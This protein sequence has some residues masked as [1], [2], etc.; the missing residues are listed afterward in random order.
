MFNKKRF[1]IGLA[2]TAGFIFLL[3]RRTDPV[4]IIESLR[5]ANYYLVL[6][7]VAVYFIGFWFKVAR[8]AYILRPIKKIPT[9]RLFS[10]TVIGYMV[11]NLLPLRIGELVRSYLISEKENIKKSTA[12]GTIAVERIFDGL[13]LIFFILIIS[14]F[15]PVP[16]WLRTLTSMMIAVFVGLLLVL[17]VISI[18][19]HLVKKAWTRP[20]HFLPVK[21]R[22]II[23][24]LGTHFIEG[25]MIVQSPTRLIIVFAYSLLL[26]AIEAAMSWVLA[27]AFAISQPYPVFVMGTATANLATT[28]PST[29]GGIGPFEYFYKQSLVLF[30]TPDS[31]ATIFAIVLHAVLLIPLIILGIVYMWTEHISF[32]QLTRKSVNTQINA[33]VNEK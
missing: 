23:S 24:D 27:F 11:N 14:L 15:V 10:I 1:W 20:L 2:F 7:A 16:D 28:L 32:S 4:E 25:I 19:P 3:F 6:P 9:K 18:S 26:W 31:A 30:G 12:L 33:P 21:W 29:Q 13:A 17:V 5:H 22:A 8:W